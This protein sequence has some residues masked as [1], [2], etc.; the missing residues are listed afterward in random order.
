MSVSLA[1]HTD[2]ALRRL[3][4]AEVMRHSGCVVV[5]SP[6]NPTFWWGN[7]LLMPRAPQPGDLA[8]W[9]RAFETKF[10]QAG[11]RTFGINTADGEAGA[12]GAFEE[13]GFEVHR[14]TVLTAGRTQAPRTFNR[15]AQVRRLEGPADW[16]AALELRLAVNAADPEPLEPADYRAFAARKLAAY[17]AAQDAGAGAF[18]GAFDADGRML[19]GLG[20]FDAGQGVA[21]YQSVE[22]HPEARS[23][24][25]AGTLVHTAG[26]WAREALGTRTLVIVADPAYHAQAL[27]ERVG[28]RPGEVQL[29]FQRRP[30]EG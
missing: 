27:Y 19:S 25:L 18:W 3:E 14:D 22:T 15:D 2:L 9:T 8:R 6:H 20:L 13:A 26:E 28:F 17:R 30:A 29:G 21:R 1:Y 5:R 11:W 12:A 24:G 10:P 16:Q 7:F 4:G 23:R